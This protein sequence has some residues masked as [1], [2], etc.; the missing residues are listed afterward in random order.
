M[1]I[2]PLHEL[3]AA[4]AGFRTRRSADPAPES[5]QEHHLRVIQ[6]WRAGIDAR[7][8]KTMLSAVPPF[9]LIV[10]RPDDTARWI[11][12]SPN[13]TIALFEQDAS[14]HVRCE[15]Q[16][17]PLLDVALGEAG[18]ESACSAVERVLA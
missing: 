1:T 9:G 13:R 5:T 8:Y 17:D 16:L 7:G 6:A 4:D 2:Q 3:P 15:Y 11:V 14:G 12:L 18:V 10:R